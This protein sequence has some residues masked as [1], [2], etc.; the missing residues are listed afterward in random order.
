MVKYFV[1]F[2]QLPR[3]YQHIGAN[4]PLIPTDGWWADTQQ[5]PTEN[6][7]DKQSNLYLNRQISENMS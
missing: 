7:S 4:S 2:D 3:L 6:F 1:D 5:I